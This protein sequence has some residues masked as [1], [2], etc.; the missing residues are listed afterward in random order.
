MDYCCL[1]D[2]GRSRVARLTIPEIPSQG[3]L[4]NRGDAAKA[5]RSPATLLRLRG[6]M[7]KLGAEKVP[8]KRATRTGGSGT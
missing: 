8:I 3:S 5:D 1:E 4:F 2:G 6:R 7:R